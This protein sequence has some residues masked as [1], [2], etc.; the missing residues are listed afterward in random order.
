MKLLIKISMFWPMPFT[1]KFCVNFTPCRNLCNHIWSRNFFK[2]NVSMKLRSNQKGHLSNVFCNWGR[3]EYV[4][5]KSLSGSFGKPTSFTLLRLGV[6]ERGVCWRIC[7]LL[8]TPHLHGVVAYPDKIILTDSKPP[9]N[10]VIVVWKKVGIMAAVK[11]LEH[12]EYFRFLKQAK[13]SQGIHS[14]LCLQPTTPTDLNGS[15]IQASN[16]L[17]H[18]GEGEMSSFLTDLSVTSMRRGEE[19]MIH[20]EYAQ[21]GAQIYVGFVFSGKHFLTIVSMI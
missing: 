19:M 10:K 11:C 13:T 1:G 4:F 9:N 3:S 21:L 15:Q 12:Q 6:E 5:I 14:A 18:V 8:F 20:A 7:L 17:S 16:I 2:A